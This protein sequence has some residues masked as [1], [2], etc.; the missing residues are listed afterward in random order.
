[1]SKHNAFPVIYVKKKRK[2]RKATPHD[3]AG[4]MPLET[5]STKMYQVANSA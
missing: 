4:L 5:T 3:F 2:K 1:M